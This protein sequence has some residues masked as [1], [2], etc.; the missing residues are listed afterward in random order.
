MLR[1]ESDVLTQR[2]VT[3]ILVIFLYQSSAMIT[4][5]MTNSVSTCK[6]NLPNRL[7]A[8]GSNGVQW[9]GSRGHIRFAREGLDQSRWARGQESPTNVSAEKSRRHEEWS[10]TTPVI[11]TAFFCFPNNSHYITWVEHYMQASIVWNRMWAAHSGS[12]QLSVHC[13]LLLIFAFC[14][15]FCFLFLSFFFLHLHQLSVSAIFQS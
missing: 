1:E 5:M 14:F 2:V 8:A 7:H 4:H 15:S 9:C 12:W 6:I 11:Y 13:K 10:G 3:Q